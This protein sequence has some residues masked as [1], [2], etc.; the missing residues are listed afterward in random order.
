MHP[1]SVTISL[2][3]LGK[4]C[5]CAVHGLTLLAKARRLTANEH[6]PLIKSAWTI[7]WK[8]RGSL[9]QQWYIRQNFYNLVA[10][11]LCFR[12]L[13]TSMLFAI[14]ILVLYDWIVLETVLLWIFYFIF[15]YLEHCALVY[16]VFSWNTACIS[17]RNDVSLCNSI[18]NSFCLP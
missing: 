15:H 11:C 18:S 2:D 16:L 13:P 10:D 4:F 8:G 3:I 6:V 14:W 9:T 17:S 7:K 1:I 5:C 12:A